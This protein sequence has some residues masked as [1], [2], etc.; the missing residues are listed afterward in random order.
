MKHTAEESDEADATDY[1]AK[2]VI[3]PD[4]IGPIG[5][6]RGWFENVWLNKPRIRVKANSRPHKPNSED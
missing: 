4:N 2:T 1:L 5:F 3:E 6:V